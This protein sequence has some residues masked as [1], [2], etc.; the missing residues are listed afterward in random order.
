MKN[1]LTFPRA[2]GR[3]RNFR[4]GS[5]GGGRFFKFSSSTR[6]SLETQFVSV[7]DDKTKEKHRVVSSISVILIGRWNNKWQ[8]SRREALFL[9]LLV[10]E[11]L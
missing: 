10:V 3:W 2:T 9:L 6:S 11:I 7:R 4:R 1:L 8:F 5:G